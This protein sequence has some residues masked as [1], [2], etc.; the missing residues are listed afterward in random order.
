MRS[1]SRLTNI[2]KIETTPI[3]YPKQLRRVMAGNPTMTVPT[4]AAKL[5]RSVSW[6]GDRLGLLKPT[7]QLGELVAAGKINMMS[8][9]ALAKRPPEEQRQF[10]DR[11]L[12]LQ[13]SACGGGIL[14]SRLTCRVFVRASI[15]ASP[16]VVRRRMTKMSPDG[17][18]APQYLQFDSVRNFRALNL[19]HAA[20]G[21]APLGRTPRS[22]G[23]PVCRE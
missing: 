17:Y 21:A 15:L 9:Y 18:P 19:P 13:R 14:R 8:A 2:H 6:A 22:S 16:S 3:Q 5:D 11:A 10:V 4:L 12:T 23:R 20:R 1:A 7:K